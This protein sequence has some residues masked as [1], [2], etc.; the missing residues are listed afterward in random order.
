[1]TYFDKLER[2]AERNR[3][4]LCVGLDPDPARIAG[5]DIGAYLREVIAATRDLVCCYKPNLAFF[6][7]LG[8]EGIALLWDVR[9]AIPNDIPVLA[10]AKRGDIGNTAEAYARAVFDTW[11]FDAV[12]VNAYGG[13]DTL[14]P[15][16][17]HTN[18]GVYVWCRSSNPG[19]ADFQDLLVA[20]DA[21]GQ[22]PLYEVIATRVRDWNTHGNAALVAGATYPEQIARLRVL[23]PD[24][25]FLL[26]GVGAQGATLHD[27]VQAAG[28][29]SGGG[30]I[31]NA[32]RGVLYAGTDPGFAEAARRAALVLRDAI[33]EAERA[34]VGG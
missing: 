12:T 28:F 1:M 6:E 8:P 10:D 30:F 11:D 2:A 17:A 22:R 19:A 20:D 32:S 25:P 7:A 4:R 14:E 27:A 18:R 31:V 33:D 5:G 3:S 26:P 34:G 16:L 13:R 21:G 15:F 23:C 9:R 24:L 29:A